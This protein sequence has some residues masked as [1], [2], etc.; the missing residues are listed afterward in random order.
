MDYKEYPEWSW[1]FA[2]ERLFNECLRAYY[3]HY[4]ASH[5]AWLPGASDLSKKAFRLKQL[6]SLPVM[7]G[8]FLHRV[9]IK[10]IQLILSG[11]PLWDADA[12]LSDARR[13]LA[14]VITKSD[15]K[16]EWERNPKSFTMLHESYYGTG[17]TKQKLAEVEHQV[18][19]CASN[20]LNSSTIETIK[21][22]SVTIYEAEEKFNYFML[23]EHKI[24][25]CMDLFF[26]NES[27]TFPVVDWKTGRNVSVD[28]DQFP[29]YGT[30]IQKKY[31]LPLDKVEFSSEFLSIGRKATYKID[32]CDILFAEMRIRRSI[33]NMQ[34]Y[35]AD[36]IVN[37]PV[38]VDAFI[39][40][41]TGDCCR[42][43]RFIESCK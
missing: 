38:D 12:I 30:Y 6:S 32:E 25:A 22:N 26:C 1:S 31:K 3:L 43:C 39:P 35:V 40:K 14:D 27:N 9:A 36:A 10:T 2:R 19:I 15:N 34:K 24:Y 20:L 42:T 16:P 33:K 23:D 21:G 11:T 18:L 8:N 5:N 41:P 28:R 29:I 17:I 4:Y 7:V 37:R 13:Y